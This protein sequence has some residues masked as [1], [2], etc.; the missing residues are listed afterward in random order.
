MAL[1]PG[2][3]L[4]T[5]DPALGA[6]KILT[7]E[8]GSN[9]KAQGMVFVDENGAHAG[10]ESNPLRTRPPKLTW[11]DTAGALQNKRIVKS[12]PGAVFEARAIVDPSVSSVRYLLFFNQTTVPV[13]GEIPILRALLP[14]GGEAAESIA[15]GKPFSI[16]I[17]VA[18]SET[19]LTLTLPG[20]AEGMFH[21]GVI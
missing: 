17:A 5:P 8:D 12:S 4:R 2:F 10:I 7:L 9:R 19:P 16:G 1:T 3:V 21:I 18:I 13:N 20:S 6:D 15:A 11:A 14:I